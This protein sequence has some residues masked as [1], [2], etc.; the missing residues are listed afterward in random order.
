MQA[1]NS[2]LEQAF[3]D[4]N[5]RC[6]V[7]VTDGHRGHGSP[8]CQKFSLQQSWQKCHV[9]TQGDTPEQ[10]T[11]TIYSNKASQALKQ[12]R[13][14]RYVVDH[15]RASGSMSVERWPSTVRQ[16]WEAMWKADRQTEY[17]HELD[18]VFGHGAHTR[19]VLVGRRVADQLAKHAESLQS[20]TLSFKRAQY[21]AKFAHKHGGLAVAFRA[22]RP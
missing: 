21:R 13:R 16:A 11:A 12:A 6:G 15:V 1:W 2:S 20:M 19:F 14:L 8:C 9:E 22:L 4:A 3:I 17:L 7:I 5:A 10:A 18:A